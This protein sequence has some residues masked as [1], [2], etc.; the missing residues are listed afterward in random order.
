M[1]VKDVDRI[2]I[3]G[4]KYIIA[5]SGTIEEKITLTDALRQRIDRL[6]MQGGLSLDQINFIKI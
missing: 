1:K 6:I 2:D 5:H 3:F 4:Q